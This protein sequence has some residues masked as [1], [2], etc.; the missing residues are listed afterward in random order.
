MC[1]AEALSKST[2]YVRNM[3]GSKPRADPV[4]FC[5]ELQKVRIVALVYHQKIWYSL[6]DQQ[7]RAIHSELFIGLY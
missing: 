4:A 5:K 3:V 1:G 2:A 7:A 6:S